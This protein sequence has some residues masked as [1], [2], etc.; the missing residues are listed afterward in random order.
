MR[1]LTVCFGFMQGEPLTDAE[2]EQVG[3]LLGA[4]PPQDW[5]SQNA[6]LTD[7]D[8]ESNGPHA[9]HQRSHMAVSGLAS[10]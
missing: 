6:G 5:R 7:L 3:Q 4:P 2:M 9:H 10:S 8:H 1:A